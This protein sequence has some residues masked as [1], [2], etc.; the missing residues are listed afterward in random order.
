[1]SGLYLFFHSN[2]HYWE[3]LQSF[4]KQ[5]MP[6]V[7]AFQLLVFILFPVR[8]LN[9]GDGII[10][11]EN[12]FLE[13]FVFGFQITLDEFWEAFLHSYLFVNSGVEDPRTIYR[14]IST[15]AGFFYLLIALRIVKNEEEKGIFY[16]TS[17]NLLLFYGYAENYTLVSLFLVLSLYLG[18][19]WL[20]ENKSETYILLMAI[21]AS[22]AVSFHLVYGYMGLS[23]LY[24][25][26]KL[27]KGTFAFV[28]N[29]VF[30]LIMAGTYLTV[31]FVFFLFYN[32]PTVS[33]SETHLLSPPIYPWKRWISLNHVSEILGVFWFTTMF[34]G[35]VLLFSYLSD[36]K[37]FC[38]ILQR[39]RARF[40][41]LAVFGFF[42]HAFF[43]NPTLG[44]PGD[45]DLFGFYSFP[46]LFLAIELYPIWKK[47]YHLVLNLALYSV[48]FHWLMASN[49]SKNPEY[50]ER[51]YK[52]S[53]AYAS[54]YLEER[55][56]I[57]QRIHK[58]SK[59]IS[60]KI[61]HFLYK[62]GWELESF[63]PESIQKMS[64]EIY[65]ELEEYKREWNLHLRETQ[66]RPSKEFLKLFLNQ[67]TNFHYRLISIRREDRKYHPGT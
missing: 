43:H 13:G 19:K 29:S 21:L 58:D 54:Q 61:D 40:F 10:L 63:H 39:P 62:S 24:F 52:Q 49:L 50:L 25:A 66:G 22:I 23:L 56:S 15:I 30:S 4:L 41:A 14:W 51:E 38:L 46:C 32:D 34:S 31:L 26:K 8:N 45:W 5:S 9:Y 12:V 48:L 1:M 27:S 28:R 53:L 59:K 2:D 60:L 18:G 37:E 67:L 57:I 11:L 33:P 42:I 64:P 17:G 35:I 44:F 6:F 7:Y 36:R 20:E 47:S 55:A 16:L 65:K 3:K